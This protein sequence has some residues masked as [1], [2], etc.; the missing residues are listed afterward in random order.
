MRHGLT[1]VLPYPAGDLFDLVSDV[2]SYPKFVRWVSA[3]RAW[4]R[5]SLGE[6]VTCLDAE[7]KVRF[8]PIGE[9]FTTRVTMDRPSLAIDVAL[10]SGPFRQLEN[11]WRFAPTSEGTRLSFDI[12]FELRSLLLERLLDANANRA[13]AA[14]VRCFEDRAAN[15]Y[16]GNAWNRPAGS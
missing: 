14:L 5:Q 13:V 1:R 12:D 3:L 7:A 9:R 10:L 4:N 16:G 8:G 2:E 15:L 6:G 11:H